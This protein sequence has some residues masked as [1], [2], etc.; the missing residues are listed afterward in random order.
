M[1]SS[2]LSSPLCPKVAGFSLARH[3]VNYNLLIVL[4]LWLSS[5]L[6]L[7]LSLFLKN[8][9]SLLIK[10]NYFVAVTCTDAGKKYEIKM[11]NNSIEITRVG[12]L[13][14]LIH[15]E[16]IALKLVIEA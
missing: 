12:P 1:C 3:L 11:A 4:K 9:Y 5:F 10:F 2:S 7:S 8:L 16:K 15:L 6:S 13:L 14:F